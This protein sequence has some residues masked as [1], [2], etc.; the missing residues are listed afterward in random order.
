MCMDARKYYR[1]GEYSEA[2]TR[3]E[4]RR[5]LLPIASDCCVVAL[6]FRLVW[7]GGGGVYERAMLCFLGVCVCGLRVVPGGWVG[8]DGRRAAARGGQVGILER[9]VSE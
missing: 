7:M 3:R 9:R 1:R 4:A 8:C 6:P 2:S 5:S